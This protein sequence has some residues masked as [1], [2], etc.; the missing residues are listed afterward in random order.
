[1]AQALG[2]L[3]RKIKIAKELREVV[4]TMKTM[5]AVNIGIYEKVDRSL[6]EYNQIIELGFRAILR[7]CSSL[8]SLIPPADSD[9]VGVV[10]FGTDQGMVGQFNDYLSNK[11]LE[12]LADDANSTVWCVG[13]RIGQKLADKLDIKQLYR[14]PDSAA[15]IAALAGS[16]LLKVVEQQEQGNIG[17]LLVCYNK[18]TSGSGYETII[19][20]L[21]PVSP[22]W[23]E[24]LHEM[25]W[26]TKMIPQVI[27]K[28]AEALGSFVREH[29]FINMCWACAESLVSENIG[30]LTAMQRARKNIDD[31][32]DEFTI[33]YN[34]ERQSSITEELF[35]IIFGYDVLKNA[36]K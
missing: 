10:V 32:L 22:E 8:H 6:A 24:N 17:K 23:L 1:M 20:Q 21:L 29:L 31:L 5:A 11:V 15:G 13:E 25:T 35:D 34:Q 14:T 18:P 9:G 4:D 26:P 16:I 30:R 36:D 3:Q 19:R 12:L 27:E 28:N 33:N 2:I 7:K